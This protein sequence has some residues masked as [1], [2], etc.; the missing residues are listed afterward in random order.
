[1]R[2]FGW[3][4]YALFCCLPSVVF[5]QVATGIVGVVEDASGSVVP[6]TVMVTHTATGETRH[7]LTNERGAFSFPYVRIGDYSVTVEAQGFK[8]KTLTGIIVRVDQ[9]VNIRM[10]LELGAVLNGGFG[11]LTSSS[12][13]G[14]QLQFGLKLNF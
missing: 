4:I 1:M 2:R 13:T 8:K 3:G 5:G 11:K 9:T 14:R 12:A 7:N 6:N 10:P